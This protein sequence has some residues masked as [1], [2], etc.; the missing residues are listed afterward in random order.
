MYKVGNQCHMDLSGVM[1]NAHFGKLTV[2]GRD[3][4]MYE[5]P[6]KCIKKTNGCLKANW[7]GIF[8]KEMGYAIPA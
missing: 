5:L 4:N 2:R 7:R 8:V 1:A 3:G 6:D